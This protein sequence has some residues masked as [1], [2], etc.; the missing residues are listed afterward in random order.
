MPVN[1]NKQNV[2]ELIEFF[3]EELKHQNSTINDKLINQMAKQ[4]AYNKARKEE[5]FNVSDKTGL[6]NIINTLLECESPFIG[7]DGKPCVMNLE[8]NKFF[9]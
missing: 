5:N 1:M 9:N 8:P 3:L 6:I 4:I 7:I 2:Q